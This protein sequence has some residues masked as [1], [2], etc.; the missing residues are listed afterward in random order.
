MQVVV[1]DEVILVSLIVWCFRNARRY[2][3]DFFM[4]MFS[5][6]TVLIAWIRAQFLCSLIC[7]LQSFKTDYRSFW[8]I[9]LL[10]MLLVHANQKSLNRS[11]TCLTVFRYC[12]WCTAQKVDF[13]FSSSKRTLDML[14]IMQQPSDSWP[15]HLSLS[16][17]NVYYDRIQKNLFFL[18][19]S[20]CWF[21]E[22]I[23]SY[24]QGTFSTHVNNN[25]LISLLCHFI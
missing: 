17:T 1:I 13:M 10:G 20:T 2:L 18:S 7:F 12:F 4:R 8:V 3:K 19:F 21:L 5:E 25:C 15:G 23:L 6:L 14:F 16:T 11:F 24:W 22:L 9:I